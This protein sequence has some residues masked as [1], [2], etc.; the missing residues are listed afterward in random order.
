MHRRQAVI[1]A[2]SSLAVAIVGSKQ[3]LAEAKQKAHAPYSTHP[4]H[5]PR[6]TIDVNGKQVVAVSIFAG[7]GNMTD[8]DTGLIYEGVKVSPSWV[9]ITPTGFQMCGSVGVFPH[10]S[11]TLIDVQV[12]DGLPWT[13]MAVY[14]L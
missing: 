11:D 1:A 8:I 12:S 10:D 5:T 7:Q 13:G 4:E 6:T 9:G 3:V 14:V 2:L